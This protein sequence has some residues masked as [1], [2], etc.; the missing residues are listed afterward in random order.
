MRL[1][2]VEVRERGTAFDGDPAY[3]GVDACG[4][5]PRKVDYDTVVAHGIACDVVAA[6]ADGKPE[7][8]IPREVH[9]A[10]DV[11]CGGAANDG[12]GMLVD[13]GVPDLTFAF[14][15]A[16]ARKKNLSLEPTFQLLDL[17]VLQIRHVFLL[18][19]V[20]AKGL[21]A[22]IDDNLLSNQ[23][24]S[25]SCLLTRK[26]EDP[27]RFFW[28]FLPIYYK[29]SRVRYRTSRRPPPWSLE[30]RGWIRSLLGQVVLM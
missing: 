27:S 25:F 26:T 24:A 13:H 10:D 30:F 2:G 16:V 29:R 9:P 23:R 7:S 8:V 21:S 6:A 19:C 1:G 11:R 12:C 17:P 28:S 20:V 14:L 3:V 4:F 15:G 22:F 5:H 18:T